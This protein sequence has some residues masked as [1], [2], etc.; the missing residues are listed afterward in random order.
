MSLSTAAMNQLSEGMMWY[1]VFLFSTVV[2]ESA[3]AFAAYKL[4]DETAYH[5]GQVTL[6][7]IPHIRQEP[8]GTVAVPILSFMTGGW[9]FGW[10]SCPYDPYWA[11]N[12]PDRSAIMSLAGPLSNLGLMLCAGMLIRLGMAMDWFY[13]PGRI[14]YTQVTAATQ[15]GTLATVATLLSILFTLN[16]ILFVFNLLPLPPLDGSGIV[17]L[18][19]SKDRAV[20]YMDFIQNGPFMMMG[21]LIAWQAFGHVFR[22][23]HTLLLNILY[24]GAGYH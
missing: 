10:A 4:G 16:T 5:N 17:P 6:D 24:P 21:L 20:G 7:P 13:A 15:D 9:M 11:R 22:P 19:L 14:N 1:L 18:F 8:I 3:H 12:H 2:H 23:I